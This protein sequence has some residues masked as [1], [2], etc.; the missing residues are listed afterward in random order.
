MGFCL[1]KLKSRESRFDDRIDNSDFEI[2]G[3]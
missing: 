2:Q 3:E 1:H